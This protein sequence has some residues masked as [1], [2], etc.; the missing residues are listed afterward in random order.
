MMMRKCPVFPGTDWPELVVL[1]Q[2]DSVIVHIVIR[3]VFETEKVAVLTLTQDSPLLS[4]E[5][6]VAMVTAPQAPPP[7]SGGQGR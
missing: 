2:W 1:L 3:S 6:V 4:R 5:V 7:L